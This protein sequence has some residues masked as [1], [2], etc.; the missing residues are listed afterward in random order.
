[1]E[2]NNYI[3][4]QLPDFKNISD[5]GHY[6]EIAVQVKHNGIW[7]VHKNDPDDIFPSDFHADRVDAPEKLDLYTGNVYSKVNKLL[8][9]NLPKKVMVYIYNALL[10]CKENN[11]LEKLSQTNKFVYLIGNT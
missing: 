5:S 10:K 4:F 7:R 11:I 3:E 9:K 8:I 6:L 2:K 1:M